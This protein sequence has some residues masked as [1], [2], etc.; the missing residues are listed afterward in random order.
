MKKI[1]L[2]YGP[3]AGIANSVLGLLVMNFFMKGEIPYGNAE[4]FGYTIMVISL[5]LIFVGVK[6]YRDKQLNGS[7]RF[8]RA[9]A[10]GLLIA[11]VAGVFYSLSWEIYYHNFMPDFLDKY[12]ALC[13]ARAKSGGANEA[14][15]QK[16]MTQ[17]SWLRE[18]YKNPLARFGITLSEILPVGI[19][20][21][22]LSAALLRKKT[23]LPAQP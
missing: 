17:L 10:M 20:V 8:G 9:L 14:E 1:V 6:S 2:I 16:L 19:L 18:I 12:E 7:I 22:L 13:I 23:L 15:M 11:L 5:S 21:S 3:A 4:I